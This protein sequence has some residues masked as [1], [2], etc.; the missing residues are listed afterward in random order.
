MK[1]P[2][3]RFWLLLKPDNKDIYQVYTYAFFKG[4]IALS[5]P[6]GIQSIIN[7]IQG[8][9]VSASWIVLVFI[10]IVGI[11]MGGYMQLMQMRI[12]ETI[13]QKI[14]ARAAFDFTYRIPKIKFEELYKHYAPEL[15]NRFFDVLTVQKS[16]AKIII[17]FSS[18]VLQII[19][20]LL[21]LSLYHPFFI[22]FSIL[23]VVLVFSIIKYTSKKG[24]ET[25]LKESKYK[26]RVVSWLEELA[27]SK[28]T[29]KLAG[30]TDL[31]QLKTDERVTGYIESR[32]KHYQVLRFQY[33]LLLIFKVIVAFG[34]LIAG[35]L[36]VLE[37]Q[38][39]IGQFVAA[40][41]IILL[42][43]DST[44]KIIVNLDNIF[45]I[46]SSLEKVGQVTD[47][48]L[49]KD[50]ADSSLQH[51]FNKPIEIDVNG[52]NYTYPGR[53]KSVIK[54]I[55]YRFEA[56]RSY[57]ISG[58][59]GS[60]KSTLIHL[61][62]GLYQPLS[63]SVC[64][65]GLPIGN[66]NIFELYKF[67][68]NALAEETI[69]EGTFYE[70]ISLG[71]D[72]IYSEDVKWAI[73]KVFLND[74]IKMLPDGLD[75]P[76]EVS[77][78]KLSK[79]VIQ[80]II[81]ARSIVNKPKLILLENHIDFIEDSEEMKIIDFLTDKSNGWTLISVSNNS[82]LKQKSDVVM[83]MTDGGLVNNF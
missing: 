65:N 5:L 18:A 51:V 43:I 52:L 71:R 32:E 56:G 57:C 12:T 16:L 54:N 31:P 11:A 33:V 3:E 20:G 76:I 39:N 30:I 46:L 82:Y 10:V 44:E 69:F 72:Y 53:T 25:A 19:F 55:T 1:T 77:G 80:K 38:M 26:Y 68:G 42:V 45:D 74:Y 78:Q 83:N 9:R 17:D 64:I 8:G 21:L 37:Q 81:L 2:L 15:M 29:F 6:I 34:L 40:E 70:N 67:I 73:E 49:E 58:S 24:L 60:G 59:N 75:S 4:M 50:T 48:D 62:A 35:G 47:L 61:L 23:L 36:L 22:L 79:S 66:Y 63:G 28:D 7:L 41:I 13:Q 27:R 14:F